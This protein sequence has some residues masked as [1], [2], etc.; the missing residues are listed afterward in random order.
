MVLFQDSMVMIRAGGA[1]VVRRRNPPKGIASKPTSTQNRLSSK[2]KH[3]GN[4]KRNKQTEKEDISP[5][6]V[7][8]ADRMKREA[9]ERAPILRHQRQHRAQL[10]EAK[11]GLSLLDLK[12][13]EGGAKGNRPSKHGHSIC[14]GSSASKQLPSIPAAARTPAQ[15]RMAEQKTLQQQAGPLESATSTGSTK[16]KWLCISD[17]KADLVRAIQM[18][19][20]MKG[21]IQKQQ[22]KL[23]KETPGCGGLARSQSQPQPQLQSR[24]LPV[25]QEGRR[26]L[27]Q[28][29]TCSETDKGQDQTM[30][31]DRWWTRNMRMLGVLLDRVEAEYQ[32]MARRP[33]IC[34]MH[35]EQNQST[36]LS[37]QL[38]SS[39]KQGPGTGNPPAP[40][41][42][43]LVDHKQL[44]AMGKQVKEARAWQSYIAHFRQQQQQCTVQKH[45]VKHGNSVCSSNL[46][47]SNSGSC[48]PQSL[49]SLGGGAASNG[50]SL[51][52]TPDP[53]IAPALA[54]ASAPALAPSP[55]AMHSQPKS[56]G[57]TD[58][59]TEA[60]VGGDPNSDYVQHHSTFS[61]NADV[62]SGGDSGNVGS[63][64]RGH[65][66]VRRKAESGD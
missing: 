2:P 18:E 65:Y 46:S 10:K 51:R 28:E 33:D 48:S 8:M 26:P 9:K 50:A 20:G 57:C 17:W 53:A 14:R 12:L 11:C 62:T 59:A 34:Y 58:A 63:V 41:S 32:T 40:S 27:T 31:D 35:V 56:S 16:T 3:R 1:S 5:I 6:L 66:F 23:S 47:D 60:E 25:L 13:G 24:S 55:E 61:F 44:A 21:K 4:S 49:H 43:L 39:P 54:S 30:A 45:S 7:Q 22:M 36:S 38:V 15:K 29:R 19:D 37:G 64:H 42:R 52:T